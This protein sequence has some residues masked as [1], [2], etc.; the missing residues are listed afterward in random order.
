M[1][2]TPRGWQ[3]RGA[4]R[5]GSWLGRRHD[6]VATASAALIRA[7]KQGDADEVSRLIVDEGADPHLVSGRCGGRTALQWA[8][9]GEHVGTMQ[10]MVG[11][12]ADMDKPNRSEH[13]QTGAK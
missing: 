2:A 3:R 1:L 4:G 7:V 5:D 10:V 6:L 11:A 8:A 12:G 13:A 9:G